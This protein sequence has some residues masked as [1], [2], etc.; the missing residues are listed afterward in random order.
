MD[1]SDFSD[2]LDS[3]DFSASPASPA[4]PA[5]QRS[6]APLSWSEFSANDQLKSPPV[7]TD[8]VVEDAPDENPDEVEDG[9]GEQGSEDLLGDEGALVGLEAQDDDGPDVGAGKMWKLVTK[10]LCF[11]PEYANDVKEQPGNQ[12]VCL[13]FS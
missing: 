6:P 3:A 7:A 8:E 12:K 10:E 2:S 11:K 13:T 5:S 9:P 1:F 4:S